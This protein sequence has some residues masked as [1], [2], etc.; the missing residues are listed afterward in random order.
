M[1]T[2]ALHTYWGVKDIIKPNI[3]KKAEVISV[4]DFTRNLGVSN[5]PLKSERGQDDV[6]FT[7]NG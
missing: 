1:L 4:G 7:V 5:P 3:G 6:S 2:L